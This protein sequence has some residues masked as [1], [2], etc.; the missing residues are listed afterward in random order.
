MRLL[1]IST[2]KLDVQ[3]APRPS[4]LEFVRFILSEMRAMTRQTGTDGL[5]VGTFF[6][7]LQQ[8]LHPRLKATDTVARKPD[9]P[10][11]LST[12]ASLI[13]TSHPTSIL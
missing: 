10:G 1:C 7:L 13:Y 8:A 5:T 9:R 2:Y 3:R 4:F 11:V 12:L 6:A